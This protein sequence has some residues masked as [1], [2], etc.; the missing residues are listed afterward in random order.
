MNDYHHTPQNRPI[1]DQ[2]RE[3]VAEIRSMRTA[4]LDPK[5]DDLRA[6]AREILAKSH[7]TYLTTPNHPP[8]CIQERKALP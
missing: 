4:P 1:T 3:F 7:P 6:K 8:K 2:W 5:P